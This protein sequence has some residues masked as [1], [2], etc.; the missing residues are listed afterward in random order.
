[1]VRSIVKDA[2]FL[3]QPSEEAVKSDL[4]IANNLL[5]TLKAH[6]GHCVGLAANMIGEKKRIIAVC[7]GKSHLVML[8]PEIVKASSEQYEAEEG[9]LSLP[10]QRKTMRHEWL[11]VVYRD[12]KFRKQQN[13]FSSFTAQIIQHEMDHCNGILI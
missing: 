10:G 13:K 12:I 5:D 6:V 8:N 4:P 7:V 2:M 9:C 1:M 11:E 3:G